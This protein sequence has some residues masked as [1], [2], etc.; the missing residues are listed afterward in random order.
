M[1]LS[2]NFHNQIYQIDGSNSFDISI[3]LAFNNPQPNIFNVSPATSTAYQDEHFVGDTRRGGSC[4]FENLALNPHCN[5]THT[6]CVGH[7]TNERISV[8]ECL[9]DAFILA[10]LISVFPENA[11]ETNDTY[12]VELNENDFLITKKSIKNALFNQKSKIKNQKS[13]II[14]TLP[15]DESKKSRNYSENPPPFFSLEAMK[16]IVELGVKHLL[17]DVPS[18]ERLNDAGKLANHR[19]F[20]NVEMGKFQTNEFSRK[21]QT[22][23]EMIYVPN[24][25]TDGEYLLNLQIPPFVSDASPSRPLLFRILSKNLDKYST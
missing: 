14:R 9:Q 8:Q 1:I 21:N 6:E 17:V 3:P 16:F 12:S 19:I 18:L 4:N 11:L 25:I 20:W 22:I 23:T 2:I 5:G 13:L 7:I 15:N 10:E 24:E